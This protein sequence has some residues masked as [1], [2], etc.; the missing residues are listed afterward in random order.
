MFGKR[1]TSGSDVRSPA[2]PPVAAPAPEPARGSVP[3]GGSGDVG[4][5]PMPSAGL[6]APITSP[7]LAP[8]NG[9]K[10]IV[11][12]ARDTRRSE[13]YYEVKG[14]IFS[15]L[16]EAIDLSQLARLDAEFGARGNPRHRQRDHRDQEHRD[17][18][19]R[20]GGTAR[21]HLQRRARLWAAGAAAG[22]RRH[23]RHH[24]ERRQYG[25]HRSRRQDSADQYPLPRQSAAAQH[26]PAHRQPDRPPRRR[27]LADLRRAP[28]GRLARQRDRAAARDRRPLA[29]HPQVQEGQADAGS[30]R[31]IR[32]DHARG[33]RNSQDHRTLPRQRADLRRYRIGQ[34]H[35]AQLSD[36]LHRHGRARHHLRGRGRIAAAA[37]ACGASRDAPAEPRGRRP[38]HHARSGQELPAYAP[39]TDHR[40]R[41][42]RTRGVRPA[43]GHEHRPR[44]LD[45][46]AARQHAA[47]G[48]LASRVR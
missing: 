24:G 4:L 32:L 14:A 15:A 25:L 26:L 12:T 9:P 48:A 30:A 18:D 17:V 37:A 6:G 8:G 7:P 13:S 27:S 39:G 22:A 45:G 36:Q 20:A 16:I 41:S 38:G 35:A 29:H 21:R 33:R 42:T 2:P 46:H 1:S 31:Q 40:R 23:R 47:R 3:S 11:P 44:R 5:S 28:A 19:L 34:D 10:P 43:A